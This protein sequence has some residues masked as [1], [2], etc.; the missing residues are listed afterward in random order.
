MTTEALDGAALGSGA[1]GTPPDPEA[2]SIQ[3]SARR[4]SMVL[5]A[6]C[7]ALV[8]VIAGVSMLTNALPMMAEDL[9]LSQ[10]QQTWVVDAYALPFAAL[11]LIAGA[12]GDRFGRRG[13]L[14]AGTVLFGIGSALSALASS[15]NELLA[16]RALTGIGA[17]LIMPGTLSTITSVF[18]ADK[19]ARAV[20]I[21]TGFAMAGG[22][23]GLLGSGLLLKWF[24]WESTF[25]VAAIIAAVALAG[26]VI[27]VPSTKAGEHVGLDPGGTV[28]SALAVGGVVFGIIE[29]PEKG[30]TSPVTLAGLAVGLIA[31]VGF[32]LWELRSTHPLLDPRLFRLPGFGTGA[33]GLFIMFLA[34]F[35]F[36]LVS[37]QF[38]QLILGYTPLAA[39]VGL[40]PMMLLAM[41]LS[42]IAAPLS[43]KVGQRR[44][45]TIGLLVAAAGFAWFSTLGAD[46]GYVDFLAGILLVA[47]GFGLAM[48]PATTAIVNSLPTAKQ[49]VASAVN[50]SA[51]EIGGAV[52]VAVLASAFNSAY[53]DDIGPKLAEFDPEVAEAAREAPAMA[54]RRADELGAAGNSLRRATESAFESGLQTAVLIAAGLLVLGAL[55]TWWRGPASV[56]APAD[57]VAGEADTVGDEQFAVAGG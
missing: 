33:A 24:S 8:L 50:D 17:A 5:W 23:L 45:T 57:E 9:D 27:A 3:L 1:A 42:A 10:T 36:F 52:G 21:W 26:I 48:T 22:T 13:A 29:G 31:S 20:G 38:L 4:R 55:Y 30:W 32:V 47:V 11:L 15:G 41:P 46:S 16:Y 34:M 39:A 53:R 12:L 54:F 56:A 7:L 44:L 6:M 43:M 19:R 35:G 18:P 25:V 40:L 51:R 14:A 2:P 28:L 37:I 49:G